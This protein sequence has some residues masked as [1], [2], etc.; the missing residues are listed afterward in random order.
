MTY[1]LKNGHTVEDP[2]L[3][4]VPQFDERSRAF[5]ISSW[6]GPMTLTKG[7]TW[8]LDLRLDQ[9]QEPT[10]VGN[11]RTHDLAASPE[12][13]KLQTGA[14]F[15][16]HF[17]V[18]LYNKAQMLDEWPGEDYEGTS[19]LAGAKAAS[20]LG[21]IGEYRWAFDHD[22]LL[23][24]I[25]FVGPAVVGTN[26]YNSMFSPGPYGILDVDPSSGVAGGH[27]YLLRGVIAN[28]DY[29]RKLVGGSKRNRRGVSL[30]RMTNSWGRNWGRDG[31]AFIWSNDYREH[32]FP[33]AENCVTT[34]AFHR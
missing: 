29:K 7:R 15:D 17:A 4:W 18:G 1:E 34:S 12:P 16:E 5:N 3:G 30:L 11:A 9:G 25:A 33:G 28:E 13:L 20:E 24:A 8:R 21:F 27:S 23:K 6:V 14:P 31:D 26:W 2:R 32:L 19:V 22:D 10:C